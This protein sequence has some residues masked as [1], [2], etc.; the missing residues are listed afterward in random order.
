MPVRRLGERERR[1]IERVLDRDP[2]G[3]STVA[4]RIATG[5]INRHPND[6][7]YGYEVAGTLESVCWVGA[8]VTP[9]MAGPAAVAA[10]AELLTGQPRWASSIIGHADAVLALWRR[11]RPAW[12][13]AREVRDNQPLLV[14]DAVPE[15]RADPHVRLA[16]P[17]E[18]DIYWPAAV[19]MYTEEV[20]VSPLADDGGD[21]HRARVAQLLQLG[22][23]YA[24]VVDGRVVFKADVAAVSRHTAQIQGV[25]VAP[26]WRGRGLGTAG[27]AAVV[28]DVLRRRIAPTVSL[29]VNHYNHV[30]RRTYA[31]CGFRQAGTLATVMF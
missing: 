10:Y 3:A 18:L 8:H 20:G 29:Y 13:P 1:A 24:R 26:D 14:T 22:R 15:V 28:A 4:E 9:V 23:S 5:R 25:W 2:Y 17:S 11:L 27:M 31:R 7:L 6:V 16:R 12:G 19:A 30:A 21:A